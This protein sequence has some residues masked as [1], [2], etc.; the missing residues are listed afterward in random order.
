MTEVARPFLKWAGGKTQMLGV[1]VDRQ[2][3]TPVDG[4]AAYF[5]PFLGGG[6]PDLPGRHGAGPQIKGDPGKQQHRGHQSVEP[7]AGRIEESSEAGGDDDAQADTHSPCSGEPG[8]AATDAPAV[9]D[10]ERPLLVLP[11]ERMVP[12]ART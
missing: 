2:P 6:A 4:R 5:E 12:L 8:L 7:E 10:D 1:L 9:L 11:H 3:P